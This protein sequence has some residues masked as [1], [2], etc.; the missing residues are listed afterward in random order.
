MDFI[1]VGICG[2]ITFAVIIV[3]VWAELIHYKYLIVLK[4]LQCD[5]SEEVMSNLIS[6][7]D[8]VDYHDNINA[9]SRKYTGRLVSLSTRYNDC[10]SVRFRYNYK[11]FMA[12]VDR[13]DK[14]LVNIRSLTKPS[15]KDI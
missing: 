7:E 3:F 1:I 4:D 14:Y 9:I 5:A 15:T 10:I 11:T 6:Y 2:G 12:D 8:I 13:F